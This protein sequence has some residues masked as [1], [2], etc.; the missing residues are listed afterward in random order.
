V[1]VDEWASPGVQLCMFTTLHFIDEDCQLQALPIACSPLPHPHTLGALQLN[2]DA[3]V[4][5]PICVRA[6][7]RG[8]T[9]DG[10]RNVIAMTNE[11][12]H[13]RMAPSR[14]CRERSAIRVHAACELRCTGTRL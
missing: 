10:A 13:Q 1:A 11:A 8:I 12:E 7:S 14:P 4:R 2:L 6:T 9:T 5:V 3:V